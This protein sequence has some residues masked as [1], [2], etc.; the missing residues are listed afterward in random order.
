MHIDKNISVDGLDQIQ[1]NSS[2][3]T[4]SYIDDLKQFVQKINISIFEN[5]QRRAT[6][7][8]FET[9]RLSYHELL[10]FFGLQ[11]LEERRTRGDYIQQYKIVKKFEKVNWQADNASKS[12]NTNG[13]ASAIR[14]HKLRLTREATT[15]TPR[16]HF[17]TNRVT[18]VWNALSQD[19][20]NATNVNVFK[21]RLDQNFKI[22]SFNCSVRNC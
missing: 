15:F 12:I 19:T 5:V 10:K 20:I 18:K 11:T 8:P 7:F 16:H 6:R 14:G 17:F 4:L 2:N 1:T 21:A 3:I 13:P 9:K 22:P